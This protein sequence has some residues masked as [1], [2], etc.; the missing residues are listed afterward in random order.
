MILQESIMFFYHGGALIEIGHGAT[1]G[2]QNG[3]QGGGVEDGPSWHP[4]ATLGVRRHGV[5]IAHWYDSHGAL[6]QG[7]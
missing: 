2:I 5:L 7:R 1:V 6:G 3:R 4:V